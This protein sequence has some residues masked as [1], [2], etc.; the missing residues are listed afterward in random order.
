MISDFKDRNSDFFDKESAWK[1][2]IFRAAQIDT[3]FRGKEGNIILFFNPSILKKIVPNLTLEFERVVES[4][5]FFFPFIV[6]RGV[7]KR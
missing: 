4:D 3:V 2:R 7:G 5:F 1:L 6:L